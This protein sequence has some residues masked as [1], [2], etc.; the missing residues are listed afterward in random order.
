MDLLQEARNIINEVDAQM[1][2]LF[3]QRMRAAEMVAQYKQLHGMPILDAER[4]EAVIRNG[5]ARVEDET[6]RGYYVDYMRNTMAVSRRYQ[7]RLLHG[8]KVAY[9]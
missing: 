7:Q 8:M 3:V 4:E 1:A 2:E 5:S 9:S 6:L